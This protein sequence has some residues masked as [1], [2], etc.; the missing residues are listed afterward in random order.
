[1]TA[2]GRDGGGPPGPERDER[3]ALPATERLARKGPGPVLVLLLVAAAFLVGVVRPWDWL[4][5][6]APGSAPGGAAPRAWPGGAAP[7]AWPGGAAPRAWPGGAAAPRTSE[8]A[9]SEGPPGAPAAAAAG[10]A[11]LPDASNTVP[12]PGAPSDAPATGA[13]AP[14]GPYV[15]PTCAYPETWRVASVQDWAGR[16]AHVWSAAEAVRATGPGDPSIPFFAIVSSTVTAIGWCAPVTGDERPPLVAAGT[17]Y[18]LDAD[19]PHA[20]PFDRL[21]PAAPDALGELWV[22]VAQSVGR[23]PPWAPGRYV[24]RL[25]APAGGYERY[26]G[27]EVVS[28]VRGDAASPAILSS[29]PTPEPPSGS[30]PAP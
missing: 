15:K 22:P 19:G 12:G 26:L 29:T 7:R 3:V 2:A 21:E 30:S 13:T 5:D 4:G 27:I 24:I 20:L 11:G 17:L 1:M 16:T 28:A 14:T 8:P 9:A 23:R 18:R 6:A 25:A 10:G